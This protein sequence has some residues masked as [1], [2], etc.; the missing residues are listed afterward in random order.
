MPADAP[1]RL[2]ASILSISAGYWQVAWL[3]FGTWEVVTEAALSRRARLIVL[4]V[5][6]ASPWPSS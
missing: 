2:A 5:P 6:A 3:L 1:A 4:A